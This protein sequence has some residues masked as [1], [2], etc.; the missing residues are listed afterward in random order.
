MSLDGVSVSA[1]QSGRFRSPSNGGVRKKRQG[2]ITLAGSS[3]HAVVSGELTRN[4][5][6]IN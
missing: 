2:G 5:K 4:M 1:D 3:F 6:C